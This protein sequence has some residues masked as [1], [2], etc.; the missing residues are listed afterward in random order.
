MNKEVVAAM[1]QQYAN[2]K[3]AI[4]GIL[5]T[6]GTSWSGEYAEGMWAICQGIAQSFE[7]SIQWSEWWTKAVKESATWEEFRAKF[8]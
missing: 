8:L 6:N 3:D 5:G 7:Q 1:I 4:K 2:Q